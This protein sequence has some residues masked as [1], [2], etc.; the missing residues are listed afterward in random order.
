MLIIQTFSIM[1]KIMCPHSHQAAVESIGN[2]GDRNVSSVFLPVRIRHADVLVERLESLVDK[3]MEKGNL[4]VGRKE[5]TRMVYSKAVA[6]SAEPGEP[7]GILAA[8]SIGEPSTQMTLNT[9]HFAGRGDMNV[10]LGIPRLREILITASAAIQTPSM[11]IPLLVKGQKGL[12]KAERLKLKL[13][14]VTLADVL[15]KVDVTEQLNVAGDSHRSRIYTLAFHFLPKDSY[16]DRFC[17][18]PKQVMRY[19]ETVFVHRVLLPGIRKEAAAQSL[20]RCPFDSF[21]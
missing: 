11:D 19:F 7:V 16:K 14:R 10:T 4:A 1:S 21:L 8:Q 6:A 2:V 20:Q 13:T 3:Y 15:E 17:V 5:L 9:F 18:K 12:R